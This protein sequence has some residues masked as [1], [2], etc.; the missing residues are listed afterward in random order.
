MF[1]IR[2]DIVTE[3]SGLLVSENLDNSWTHISFLQTE[4]YFW[5]CATLILFIIIV[6]SKF[7][8]Q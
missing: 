6:A 2:F 1:S 3:I 4:T 7:A 8:I 5:E